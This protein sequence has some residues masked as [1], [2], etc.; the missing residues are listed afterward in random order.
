MKSTRESDNDRLKGRSISF[1]EPLF[2]MEAH[3]GLS[4]LI[5]EHTGFKAIWASGLS[6]STALGRRDASEICPAEMLRVFERIAEVTTVPVLVDADSGYGNFNNARLA[7]R[8]LAQYSISG[9]CIEDKL[10]P[11]MNSFVGSGQALADAQEFCGKI[12]AIRD[13][14]LGNFAVVARTEALISGLGMGEALDRAAAYLDAGADA[15]LIHSKRPDA[16]E[17][18]EFL[19]QWEGRCPV[20]VVPTTYYQTPA[21]ELIRAG[22]RGV[23]WANH[24]IRASVAA[25]KKACESIRE[26]GGVQHLE[27]NVES[28]GGLFK[29]LDYEELASAEKRYLPPMGGVRA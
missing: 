14:G 23:I 15:I 27:S 16:N 20:V 9:M 28:L 5:A 3:D 8:K 10:H 25:M 17:I 13:Q 29:L 22:A 1:D 12:K 4:A 7:A 6:I 19:R 24:S 26:Q 2:F 18:F 11:K 21:S